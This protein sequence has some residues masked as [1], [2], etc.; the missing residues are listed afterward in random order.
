MTSTRTRAPVGG[1]LTLPDLFD[2]LRAHLGPSGWWPADTRFE[3]AVGAVLVQNTN[4]RNVDRSLAAL[5]AA[6]ATQ[7][8]TLLARAD[9][10][11][12]IRP[13]GFQT[14]KGRCLRA[15]CAWLVRLR[16]DSHEPGAADAA[17]W[18]GPGLVRAVPT[19]KLR[20]RLLALPGIGPETADALLLYVFDRPTFV[21]DRYTRRLFARLGAAP[22]A[23]YE[24]M[25]RACLAALDLGVADLQEFHGLL[26]DFAKVACRSDA[27]WAGSFLAGARLRLPAPRLTRRGPGRP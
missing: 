11:A 17:P 27:A 5:R 14:A 26:D 19:P 25:R 9:L 23:G 22:P 20:E 24:G 3:I 12:L 15:L 16:A 13:S 21:A 2:A 8:R 1:T 6:G 4:W 10:E 18:V 7:P